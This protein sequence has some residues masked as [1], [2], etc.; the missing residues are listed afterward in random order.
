MAVGPRDFELENEAFH[1]KGVLAVGTT[2][3]I[4]TWPEGTICALAP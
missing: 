1:F 2:S 4:V 3:N